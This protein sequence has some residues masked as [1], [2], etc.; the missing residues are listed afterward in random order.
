M[1]APHFAVLSPEGGRLREGAKSYAK[2]YIAMRL[3]SDHTAKP[4][5]M[6]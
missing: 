2:R 3:S 6:I 4:Y 1:I 5:S